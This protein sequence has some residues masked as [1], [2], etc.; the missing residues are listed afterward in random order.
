MMNL[1]KKKKVFPLLIE[2]WKVEIIR[3]ND[4]FD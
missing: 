3:T 4:A 2:K 1:C